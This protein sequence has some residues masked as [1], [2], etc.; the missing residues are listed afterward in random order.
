MKRHLLFALLAFLALSVSAR[1]FEAGEKLYFNAQPEGSTWWKDGTSDNSVILWGRL[2]NS[3]AEYWI[4][5]KWYGSDNC[6]L[7]IPND[8][9]IL[10]RTWDKLELCRC[11]N[12]NHV[13]VYTRTGLID[14]NASYAI[15]KNYIQ[16]FNYGD[17]NAGA[18]WWNLTFTPIENPTGKSSVDRKSVV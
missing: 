5:A 3:T 13:T 4:K 17:G 18:N 16:K 6:Y 7:E 8:N 12:D 11:A 9:F 1:E 14:I 2:V 15:D 10:S